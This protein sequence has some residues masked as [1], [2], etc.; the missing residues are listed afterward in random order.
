MIGYHVHPNPVLASYRLRVAIPSRHLGMAYRVGE[1]GDVNF[2]YKLGNPVLAKSCAPVVFDVV[3]DHFDAHPTVGAMCDLAHTIT[4]ASKAMA[5]TVRKHTGRDAVVI[6]DPYE[7]E[8]SPPAVIGERIVWFGHSANLPSLNRIAPSLKGFRVTVCTDFQHPAFVMWSPES[9]KAFLDAAAVVVISG[10]NPGASSNRV[11]KALRAGR[12]V[13]MPRDC[14]R[15][16]RQFEDF[17]FIGDVREG[18]RWALDNREEACKR[19][20]AGQRYIR[21]RFSP[22]SI[23]LQWA[24]LFGSILGRDTINRTDGSGSISTPP[25]EKSPQEVE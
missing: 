6:D 16:W 9:E 3:N 23:G 25:D 2:F 19:I 5:E 7:N 24:V 12:F 1:R 13:V 11:V 10:T 20:Q 15:S 21:Q 18:V 22:Q 8:E 4:V 17:C 14:A